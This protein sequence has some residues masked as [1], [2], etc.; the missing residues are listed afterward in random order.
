M[1]IWRVIGSTRLHNQAARSILVFNTYTKGKKKSMA[2][3]RLTSSISCLISIM[4]VQRGL[5]KSTS[6]AS[7]FVSTLDRI[8][9]K[10]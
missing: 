8:S 4:R 5:L 9:M 6:S 3:R 10:L 7:K 1:G 2:T